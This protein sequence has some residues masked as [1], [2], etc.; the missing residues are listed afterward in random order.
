[1]D[2]TKNNKK[3]TLKDI[4][5]LAD[6]SISTVSM[7]LRRDGSISS[8]V[9]RKVF[10]IAEE[11]GYQK[12]NVTLFDDAKFVTVIEYESFDYQ[13]NFIKPFLLSMSEELR[14]HNIFPI[15]HH[16]DTKNPNM[17]EL[18]KAII[19]SGS[20]AVCT[21]HFYDKEFMLKLQQKG[22]PVIMLNNNIFQD[23]FSSVCVDDFQGAYNGTSYL[24]QKGHRNILYFEYQRD[25][26]PSCVIDRF[27]GFKKAAD[28]YRIGFTDSQR[29]TIDLDDFPSLNVIIKE[30][31][32]EFPETTAIFFHDDYLA[33]WSIPII[34]NLGIDI[35]GSISLVAPGD[36]LDFNQPFTPKFTTIKIDT[37]SMGNHAAR[38]IAEHIKNPAIKYQNFKLTPQIVERGSCLTLSKSI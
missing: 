11:L 36:T 30:K 18:E 5:T 24:I 31:L 8:D 14:T 27:L 32:I 6:V 15:I 23:D 25:E 34:K 16:L 33:S 12:K 4:A 3:P 37:Y 17:E 7:V 22:I 20:S 2:S 29:I 26:L 9:A 1:M 13:W 10:Q 28:E 19:N 21:I 35:P 38:L